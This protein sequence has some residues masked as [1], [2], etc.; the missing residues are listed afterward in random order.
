MRAGIAQAMLEKLRGSPDARPIRSV[1][2][3]DSER[4][5]RTAF[6]DDN[7]FEEFK[8]RMLAE[9]RMKLTERQGVKAAPVD[10][11]NAQGGSLLGA[12]KSAAT[13][14][15]GNAVMNMLDT[16]IPR[17]TGMPPQVAQR[18]TQKLL[19]PT[20]QSG[21]GM[22]P[23]LEGIM[24]TLKADEA[25]IARMGTASNVAGAMAGQQGA[26]QPPSMQGGFNPME[27][28]GNVINGEGPSQAP[29]MP[30]MQMPQMQMP[31]SALQQAAPQPMPFPQ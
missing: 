18:T 23:I 28:A 1:L 30:Q 20:G 15:F 3:G 14:N 22:D 7:A 9:E 17:V 19:T 8:K 6:Q 26:A 29:Q 16:A 11:E 31:P 5:L 24:A 2:G 10:P 21:T 4:K 27:A 25:N 13:G 12:A